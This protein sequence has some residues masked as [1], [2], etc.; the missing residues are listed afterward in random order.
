M[1]I[2]SQKIEYHDGDTPLAGLLYA[3]SAKTGKRPGLLLVHHA[4][5]LDDHTKEHAASYADAGFVVFAGDMYGPG[6]AGN[7]E[8]TTALLMEMRGNPGKVECHGK[9]W[10][11]ERR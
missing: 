10:H 2:A 4:Y 1:A 8:R 6:V 9:A 11:L 7:R 5:G 3:D